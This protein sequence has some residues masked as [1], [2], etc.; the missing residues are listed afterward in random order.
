[1]SNRGW[2]LICC[3]ALFFGFASAGFVLFGYRRMEVSLLFLGVFIAM[4]AYYLVIRRDREI[5]EAVA[6]REKDAVYDYANEEDE[7]D[8]EVDRFGPIKGVDYKQ[9]ALDVINR[10]KQTGVEL[11]K[12]NTK[13]AVFFV[14]LVMLFPFVASQI[15]VFV[16]TM[17]VSYLG[18]QALAGVGMI[19]V[20][21]IFVLCIG[22]GIGIG[23]SIRISFYLGRDDIESAKR[24][25]VNTVGMSLVVSLAM[26][27]FFLVMMGPILDLMGAADAKDY[28]MQ[29]A[30]P[31][32]ICTSFTVVSTVLVHIM[33]AEG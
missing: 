15:N 33:R 16:D 19:K 31:L 14:S 18:A 23:G 9:M 22:N 32:N 3:A 25:A 17:W 28:A 2:I 30:L 5:I 4:F 26:T 10:S 1:M 7:E 11:I 20:F 21:Y 29:Y 24:A 13:F 12:G 27:V 6:E 8:D